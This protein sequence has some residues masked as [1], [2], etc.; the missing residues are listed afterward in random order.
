MTNPTKIHA[1]RSRWRLWLAIAAVPV[2]AVAVL[3]AA[4][5][6]ALRRRF[7][8]AKRNIPLLTD[9]TTLARGRHLAVVINKCVDCH[10]DD[11]GGSVFADNAFFGRLAAPNL[12]RGAGGIGTT[13]GPADIERAVRHGVGRNGRGLVYMPSL[14]W[15]YMTDED[16]TALAA[17][18]SQVPPVHRVSPGTTLRVVGRALYLSG[19]LPLLAAEV[20]DHDKVGQATPRNTPQEEGKYLAW[21]G[22]CHGCHGENLKG[23][24][25]PGLPPELPPAA[26][27]SSQALASWS[28]ADFQKVLRTGVRPDGR[29]L[30]PLMPYRLTAQM[31][32]EEIEA[33]FAYLKGAQI[34]AHTE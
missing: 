29:K 21:T 14:D 26:N 15:Q 27:I 20:I 7:D 34:A 2:L 9:S 24:P 23:G 18:I 28:Y 12:T 11:L 19:K 13:L 3:Y 32:E 1:S 4:S 25:I 22:G 33:L 10:G 8:V 17:Y 5:E 6:Y 31:K 30:H 16:I